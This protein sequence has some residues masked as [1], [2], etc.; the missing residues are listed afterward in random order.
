[1][2]APSSGGQDQG[3]RASEPA[4]AG[5]PDQTMAASPDPARPGS[6]EVVLRL[7]EASDALSMQRLASSSYGKYVPC[8]GREPA[9]MADDYAAVVARGHA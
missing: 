2:P 7:A 9:P 6:Q 1:M 4:V 5:Q 3:R 8:M